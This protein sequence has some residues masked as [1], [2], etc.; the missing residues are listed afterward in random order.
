MPEA[1]NDDDFNSSN[2][3]LARYT[4]THTHRLRV[5]K[6]LIVSVL[7]VSLLNV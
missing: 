5:V 6:K 1:I 7:F 3:S 4:H 2:K